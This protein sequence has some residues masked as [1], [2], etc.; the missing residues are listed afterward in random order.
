MV[1]ACHKEV[2]KALTSKRVESPASDADHGDSD[3]GSS[4][5][6]GD[7]NFIGF[8]EEETKPLS[9][10]ISKKVRKAVRNV[11]P[12]YINQTTDNLKEVIQKELEEFKREGIMKDF[13]NEMVTYRYFIACDVPKFDGTLHPIASIRWLFA[14]EGA[15]RTS[16]CKE[17]N[18][19]N[20]A[21]SF[22]CESAKMWWDE[23]VCE[24]G[25]EWLGLC[26]WKKFN[27]LFNV[28]YC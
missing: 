1:N 7:Y 14:V 19:V 6:F 17:K 15:F 21:S 9:S 5:S 24:K 27:E 28:E 10:M 3:N 25:E 18:K 22:L 13:R 16:C 12:Y 23:K 11:M 26:S 8:V 20:F 4:S 2:L